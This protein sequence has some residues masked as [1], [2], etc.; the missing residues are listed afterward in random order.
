MRSVYICISVYLC[1][2]K[3]LQPC[4]CFNISIL[5]MQMIYISI[6]NKCNT[7]SKF[8]R[9]LF[10][11]FTFLFQ[12]KVDNILS[13]WPDCSLMYKEVQRIGEQSYND[14]LI[15][16]FMTFPEL[17]WIFII[18]RP[19]HAL[20]GHGRSTC[21]KS[22]WKV[23]NSSSFTKLTGTPVHFV[24][25]PCGYYWTQHFYFHVDTIDYVGIMQLEAVCFVRYIHW[26]GWPRT[27]TLLQKPWH[28][29]CWNLRI[30]IL[31]T[32]SDQGTS[33]TWKWANRAVEQMMTEQKFL[34]H[35]CIFWLRTVN[36]APVQTEDRSA[37]ILLIS[38]IY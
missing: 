22:I 13:A 18:H 17:S 32:R 20:L 14:E 31:L 25:W 11:E 15:G 3:C 38:W 21:K 12:K 27:L 26:L 16:I 19:T 5:L 34:M 28:S 23:P 33:F 36:T 37:F 4:A 2:D 10:L 8:N 7:K 6:S 30:L 1:I 24:L 9:K 35:M 29:S